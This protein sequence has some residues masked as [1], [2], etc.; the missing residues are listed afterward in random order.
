MFLPSFL[1]VRDAS[2]LSLVFVH[3]EF[4]FVTDVAF[5]FFLTYHENKIM[6]VASRNF[7]P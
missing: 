7:S 4:H 6:Q 3:L 1:S 5:F 2:C